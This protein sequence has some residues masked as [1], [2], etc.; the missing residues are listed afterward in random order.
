MCVCMCVSVC[1]VSLKDICLEEVS[2]GLLHW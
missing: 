2:S 1:K